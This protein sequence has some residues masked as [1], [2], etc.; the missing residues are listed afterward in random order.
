MHLLQVDWVSIFEPAWVNSSSGED[1][2]LVRDPT[3]LDREERFHGLSEP[4]LVP[5][6]FD[7]VALRTRMCYGVGLDREGRTLPVTSLPRQIAGGGTRG[8]SF[9]KDSH[10]PRNT[11]GP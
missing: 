7:M 10:P 6:I 5:G 3:Q 8:T 4:C 2:S 1:I 11:I 9:I